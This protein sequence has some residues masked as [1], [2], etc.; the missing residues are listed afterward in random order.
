MELPWRHKIVTDW[1]ANCAMT[2]EEHSIAREVHELLLSARPQPTDDNLARAYELAAAERHTPIESDDG[3]RADTSLAI[4]KARQ[5]ILA[6]AGAVEGEKLL[7]DA[8]RAVE[9]WVRAR[10]YSPNCR[11]KE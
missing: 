4:Q 6:K 3:F 10:T 7:L 1:G 8:I 5:A 2:D 11:I 9:Q